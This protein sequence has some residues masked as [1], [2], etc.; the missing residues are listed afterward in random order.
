MPNYA[1]ILQS[2]LPVV[3]V[4]VFPK[5][6]VRKFL[7]ENHSFEKVRLEIL[8]PRLLPGI[9]PTIYRATSYLGNVSKSY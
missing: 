4:E 6:H 7:Q 8:H 3:T 5:I 1:L 9:A 2:I